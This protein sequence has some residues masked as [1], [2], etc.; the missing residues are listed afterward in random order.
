M[1]KT[2]HQIL[3]P[4]DE[5]EELKELI[6]EQKSL[7]HLLNEKINELD[8]QLESIGCTVTHAMGLNFMIIN[9]LADQKEED[10]KEIT[11]LIFSSA[12]VG[13]EIK[14]TVKSILEKK[15]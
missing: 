10:I 1:E 3:S 6:S 4:K 12:R 15:D 11:H 13:D 5:I 9:T 8:T 14:Q 2:P 7:I